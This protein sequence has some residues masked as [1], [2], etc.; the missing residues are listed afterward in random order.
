[1]SLPSATSVPRPNLP[2]VKAMAPNTPSGATRITMDMMRK[3]RA[4]RS[5]T[6][7]TTAVAAS[8]SRAS[9]TP[10]S[11]EKKITWSTSSLAK[12]STTSLGMMPSRNSL[13]VSALPAVV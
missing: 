10:K 12:A 8:R 13:A 11:T 7:A 2:V 9:A 4:E 1:M 5:S 3:S 6:K